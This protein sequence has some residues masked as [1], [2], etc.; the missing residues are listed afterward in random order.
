MPARLQDATWEEVLL[1]LVPIWI[2]KGTQLQ[3]FQFAKPQVITKE[4]IEKVPG[5][6]EQGTQLLPKKLSYVVGGTGTLRVFNIRT[7]RRSEKT[8]L[9]R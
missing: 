6:N 5:W 2:E 7:G 8:I 4:E 1:D 3:E 9:I